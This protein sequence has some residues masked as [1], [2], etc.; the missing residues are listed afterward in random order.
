MITALKA[1]VPLEVPKQGSKALDTSNAAV[2][3]T[4]IYQL[5]TDDDSEAIDVIQ[6]NMDLLHFVLGV[7]ACSKLDYAIKQFDFDMALQILNK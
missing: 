4:R 5:L 3:L 2:V 6:Q 7:E 1:A